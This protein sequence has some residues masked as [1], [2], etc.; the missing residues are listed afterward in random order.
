MTTRWTDQFTSLRRIDFDSNALIYHLE[1]REPYAGYVAE[2]FVTVETFLRRLSGLTVR[3]VD[4]NIA[5]RAADV[6]AG[7]RLASLDSI[8]VP[9]GLEERCDAIIGND[10]MIASRIV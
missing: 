10:A 9:T 4:R 1:G 8:I 5:R 3:P 2:A 6:Y 7:T